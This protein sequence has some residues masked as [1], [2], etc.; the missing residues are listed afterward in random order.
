MIVPISAS[1][2][3]RPEFP[4]LTRIHPLGQKL[5]G[6]DAVTTYRREKAIGVI[7]SN[8]ADLSTE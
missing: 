3:A 7:A 1:L 5:E 8:L 6:A 2:T 4:G